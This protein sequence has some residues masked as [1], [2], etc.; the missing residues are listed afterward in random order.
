[1]V[2]GEYT[3]EIMMPRNWRWRP[4]LVSEPLHRATDFRHLFRNTHGPAV[5][6]PELRATVYWPR[7]LHLP[8]RWAYKA[9]AWWLGHFIFPLARPVLTE[10]EAIWSP[11]RWVLDLFEWHGDAP[12][13]RRVEAA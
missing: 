2:T 8:V 9:Y 11:F 4:F 6:L 12:T 1:M 5:F 3:V 10:G 7:P 13:L